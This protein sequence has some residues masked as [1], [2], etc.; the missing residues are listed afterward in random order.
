[1]DVLRRE[2]GRRR[3]NK[4]HRAGNLTDPRKSPFRSS[5]SNFK[6]AQPASGSK[7][8]IFSAPIAIHPPPAFGTSRPDCMRTHYSVQCMVAGAG[9]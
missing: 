9:A 4:L 5:N 8:Q 6:H 1:M 3:G 2:R 7:I